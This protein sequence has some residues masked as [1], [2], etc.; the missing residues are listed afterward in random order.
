MHVKRKLC[1]LGLGLVA[2]TA[3]FALGNPRFLRAPSARLGSPKVIVSW[4]EVDLINT[5]PVDYSLSAKSAIRYQCVNADGTCPAYSK[6]AEL[7]TDLRVGGSFA[8]EKGGKI[9]DA[10]VIPAPKSG[11]VCPAGQV[12]RVATAV[13]THIKLKDV[14]NGVWSYTQPSALSYN[15]PECPSY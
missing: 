7:M 12:P 1:L 14:T 10:M 11:L 13:F 8:V 3:A 4:Q 15:G 2:A 6:E 9:C 5:T